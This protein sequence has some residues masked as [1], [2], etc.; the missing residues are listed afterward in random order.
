KKNCSKFLAYTDV[1]M[2]STPPVIPS[3]L[4]LCK[5]CKGEFCELY[6]FTNKGLADAQVTSHSTDD[7]ALTL[8]Q[9]DHSLHSFI[10]LASA[11][12]KQNVIDDKDLL[13]IQIDE[14][15]P[16]IICAM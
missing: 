13:W 11:K 8:I 4:M 15:T 9:D 16:R 12:A 14:A 10:P 3:P 5:L 6:F 1:P 7:E 2:S